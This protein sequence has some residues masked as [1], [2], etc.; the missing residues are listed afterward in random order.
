[1][2]CSDK[3]KYTCGK[4]QNARCTFYELDLPAWSSLLTEDCVTIEET[5][6]ELYDEVTAI[7]DFLDFDNLTEDCITYTYADVDS[8]KLSE[9]INPITEELCALKATLEN[10]A[11]DSICNVPLTAC[12]IDTECLDDVCNTGLNTIG[13]LLQAM[14]TKI[15]A[16]DAQV[17][18]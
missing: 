14:I 12:N 3:L 16:I 5:T 4:R 11:L 8:K 15:C 10:Q 2:C 9:V 1:M 13:D 18:P 7:K 6:K 17:N